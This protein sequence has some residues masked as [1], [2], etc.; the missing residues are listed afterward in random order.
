MPRKFTAKRGVAS[1]RFRQAY[2]YADDKG[3]RNHLG[4]RSL[5]EALPGGAHQRNP[6]IAVSKGFGDRRRFSDLHPPGPGFAVAAN[7]SAVQQ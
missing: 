3:L 4:R 1:S 5:C 2:A 7:C 6:L